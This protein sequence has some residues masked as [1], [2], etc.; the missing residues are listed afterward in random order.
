[1]MT[2][3]RLKSLVP[4]WRL[5]NAILFVISFVLPW[6]SGC[7]FS[8]QNST[9]GNSTHPFNG[10]HILVLAALFF[11]EFAKDLTTNFTSFN[12]VGNIFNHFFFPVFI[13]FPF[14]LILYHFFNIYQFFK[15]RSVNKWWRWTALLIATYGAFSSVLAFR[16]DLLL[17]FW[18]TLGVVVSS[19]V[20]EVTEKLIEQYD[21]RSNSRSP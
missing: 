15:P 10:F 16:R 12:S 18:L 14:V 6:L 19:L 13:L 7:S 21:T 9:A 8:L 3:S 11:L 1:M 5:L 20:L 4:K 17:G 2:L